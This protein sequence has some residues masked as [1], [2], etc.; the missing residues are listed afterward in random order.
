MPQVPFTAF[1]NGPLAVYPIQTGQQDV[2]DGSAYLGTEFLEDNYADLSEDDVS[3]WNTAYGTQLKAGRYRI[4]RLAQNANSAN[5]PQIAGQGVPVGWA[6]GTY[7]GSTVI[8]AGGT[9]GTA[10][11]YNVSST[12]NAGSQMPAIAQVTVSGGAI[13]SSQLVQGGGPF[14]AAPTFGLTEVPGLSGGSLLAQLYQSQSYVSS[15]DSTSVADS[16]MV[17]GVTYTPVS[18]AQ[19][20][21][22]SWIVVQEAG[23]AQVLVTT[24]TNTAPGAQAIAAIGGAVTTRNP[25]TYSAVEIGYTLALAAAGVTVPTKL[26]IPQVFD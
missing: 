10:G 5:L 7:V 8:A 14:L 21:A 1:F 6:A 2:R 18:A 15:F 17:R 3:Q 4:C 12:Y 20:A 13:I 25:G 11:T 19:I 26:T 22:G 24:A 16:S 9:G 23:V